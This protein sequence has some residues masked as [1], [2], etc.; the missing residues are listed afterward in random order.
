MSQFEKSL[1]FLEKSINFRKNNNLLSQFSSGKT[2]LF[3]GLA[4]ENFKNY[5][6]ASFYFKEYEKILSN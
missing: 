6:K 3:A 4:A 5:E 2:Y 1:N